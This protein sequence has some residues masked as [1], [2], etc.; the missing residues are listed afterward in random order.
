MKISAETTL[1]KKYLSGISNLGIHQ[2]EN[3]LEKA[4]EE[5]AP[6][7]E[8]LEA[9]QSDVKMKCEEEEKESKAQRGQNKKGK[10]WWVKS[11][12]ATQ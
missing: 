12:Q 4:P 9:D 2:I 1:G 5:I 8:G 6:E 3:S 11:G 10:Q 7:V